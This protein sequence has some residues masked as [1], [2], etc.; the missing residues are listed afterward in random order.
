MKSILVVLA[1]LV[2]MFPGPLFACGS[3]AMMLP[4]Y[5]NPTTTREQQIELLTKLG[6]TSHVNYRPLEDDK[7]IAA[8][9]VDAIENDLPRKVIEDFL[10]RYHCV[11]A[12]RH[13]SSYDTIRSFIGE[14]QYEDFCNTEYLERLVLVRT[15][16]GAVLRDGPSIGDKRIIAIPNG[17]Y[18]E[19]LEA[20]GEWYRVDGRLYGSGYVHKS[21]VDKY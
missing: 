18:L 15:P 20:D 10:Q 7:V 17:V 1:T 19:Q 16:S 3:A 4:S 9:L 11:Y 12:A 13:E 14:D 2:V 6:C 5:W 21:L 8:V